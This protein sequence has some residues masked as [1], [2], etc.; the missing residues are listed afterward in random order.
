MLILAFEV[1]AQN[2][3]K[4]IFW[5]FQVRPKIMKIIH[6][7]SIY[8]HPVHIRCSRSW[9]CCRR[10]AARPFSRMEAAAYKKRT[11]QPSLRN[12][13]SLEILPESSTHTPP[14]A[15]QGRPTSN[16]YYNSNKTVYAE[17]IYILIYL[18]LA[19][20]TWILF[21]IQIYDFHIHTDIFIN[22]SYL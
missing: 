3:P 8:T 16:K 17:S 6:I 9:S 7:G 11:E 22:P 18:I 5:Y 10:K 4:H 2:H 14:T 12:Y 1:I 15:S 19:K 13:L 21:F 20:F